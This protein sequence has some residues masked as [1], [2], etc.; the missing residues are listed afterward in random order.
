MF[1]GYFPTIIFLL[2]VFLLTPASGVAQSG[3]ITHPTPIATFPVTG[4]LPQGIYYYEVRA[5]AGPATAVLDMTPPDGGAS[6]SVSISGPDCCTAEAYVSGETGSSERIRRSSDR[7]TVPSRQ[8][9][10]FTVNIAVERGKTVRF[11]L[12]YST[13][14]GSGIIVTPPPTPTPTP[15]P[16]AASTGCTDL[17]L[18]GG[19]RLAGPPTT[20]TI[21]FTLRNLSPRRYVGTARTQW[22]ELLDRSRVDDPPVLITIRRFTEVPAGGSIA[23]SMPH[24]PTVLSKLPQRYLV[25]IVYSP[26]NATDRLTTNDDCVSGNNFTDGRPRALLADDYIP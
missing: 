3:D 12:N 22:V 8:M 9:L 10:L 24:S 17:A 19:F 1:T 11:S 6:M 15:A 26:S 5:N 13:R 4:N 16:T 25:R 14:E 7:F 23:F 20:R 2:A 18:N 21:N